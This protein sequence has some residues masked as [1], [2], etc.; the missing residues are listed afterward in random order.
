MHSGGGRLPGL[1]RVRGEI[2]YVAQTLSVH[3][4]VT[5]NASTVLLKPLDCIISTSKKYTAV[6]NLWIYSLNS[7]HFFRSAPPAVID[8]E[9]FRQRLILYSRRRVIASSCPHRARQSSVGPGRPS[10]LEECQQPE[11]DSP[12]TTHLP[13]TL[14]LL[15]S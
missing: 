6:A 1:G 2:R 15:L 8:N 10:Q 14:F 7:S 4:A 11:L 13:L 9:R 12:G 5:K 3:R